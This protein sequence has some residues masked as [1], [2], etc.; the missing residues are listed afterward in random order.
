MSR[1]KVSCIF[2]KNKQLAAQVDDE[3]NNY[4]VKRIVEYFLFLGLASFLSLSIT[5]ISVIR[6]STDSNVL[7]STIPSMVG[8]F[9]FEFYFT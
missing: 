7:A 1:I 8:F 3:L 5:L 4:S 2:V 6:E 9:C